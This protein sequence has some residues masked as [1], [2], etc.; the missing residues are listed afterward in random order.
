MKNPH[1][2]FK[3]LFLSLLTT[4]AAVA[5]ENADPS[6]LDPSDFYFQGWMALRDADEFHKEEDYQK[7]FEAATRCKR[8]MD[9]VTLYHSQWKP[10]LIERKQK[11]ALSKLEILAPLLPDLNNGGLRLYQGSAAAPTPTVSP[12][13]TPAEVMQA[14]QIQRE[15]TEIKA[16]LG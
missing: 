6:K 2:F 10:H 12:G 14:T 7:A 9:T 15:L 16:K 4:F 13:L 8:L 5:Q 1:L 3:V 11:E